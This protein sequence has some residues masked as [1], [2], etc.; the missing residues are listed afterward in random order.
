MVFR[1]LLA[2]CSWTQPIQV[3]LGQEDMFCQ[4]CLRC[5]STRYRSVGQELSG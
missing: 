5:A 1:C 2:G 3:R 4:R